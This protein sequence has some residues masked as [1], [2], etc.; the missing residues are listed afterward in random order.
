VLSTAPPMIL[1]ATGGDERGIPWTLQDV[2]GSCQPGY[3]FRS[4]ELP[5][6]ALVPQEK[7]CS[8]RLKTGCFQSSLKS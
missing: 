6:M 8:E 1:Q 7:M 4:R 3:I 5:E 2:V